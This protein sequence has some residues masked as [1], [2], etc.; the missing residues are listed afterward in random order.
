MR[1]ICPS[2]IATGCAVNSKASDAVTGRTRA[3]AVVLFAACLSALPASAGEAQTNLGV[4]EA[5]RVSV[6]RGLSRVARPGGFAD[7]AA[8]RIPLPDQLQNMDAA[9]RLAGEQKRLDRFIASLSHAAESSAAST[10]PV[11]L[12]AVSEMPIDGARFLMAGDTG[13]TDA[14]RRYAYGRVIG[15]LDPAVVDAMELGRV[16]RRYRKLS[17][18]LPVGML[19]P[20]PTF[21]LDAYVVGR[22]AD[23]IFLAISQEERRI[24]TDPAARTS[25]LL[26]DVFG[27][28]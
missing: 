20:P 16:T 28:R 12:T 4:R 24:R 10:R 18:D 14:L 1:A 6:E 25:P 19:A 22:T 15:V 27:A 8:L 13:C 23:G 5:L 9:M 7:N 11:L 21:D 2:P 17:R 26:R 3:T